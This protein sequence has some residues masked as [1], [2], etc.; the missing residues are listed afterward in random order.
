M[1][2]IRSWHQK[3]EGR[4][5]GGPQMQVR[6]GISVKRKIAMLSAMVAASFGAAEAGQAAGHGAARG[7]AAAVALAFLAALAAVLA[8]NARTHGKLG[9]CA[10]ILFS[11]FFFSCG[12]ISLCFRNGVF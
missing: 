4:K 12:F 5:P 6:V 3:S 1:P 11:A 2:D 7:L 8:L 10:L 9:E